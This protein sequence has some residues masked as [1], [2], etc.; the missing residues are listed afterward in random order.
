MDKYILP[1]K[2]LDVLASIPD[3]EGNQNIDDDEFD[4]HIDMLFNDDND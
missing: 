4:N 3:G 2:L 1:L